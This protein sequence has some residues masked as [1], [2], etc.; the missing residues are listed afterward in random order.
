MAKTEHVC[1]PFEG[2]YGVPL[3]DIVNYYKTK[4]EVDYGSILVLN[5]DE[6]VV[7]KGNKK[8]KFIFGYPFMHGFEKE[9]QSDGFMTLEEVAIKIAKYCKEEYDR[10]KG[11][12]GEEAIRSAPPETSG[13]FFEELV[14]SSVE[15]DHTPTETTVEVNLT[16]E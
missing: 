9:I 8:V 3:I 4:E 16:G 13:Y 10:L 12:P 5:G 2:G 6:E 14:L 15:I 7:S 11:A 1:N